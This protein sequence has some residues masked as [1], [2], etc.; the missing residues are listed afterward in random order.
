M[1]PGGSKIKGHRFERKIAH[2][3]SEWWGHPGSFVRTP[4]SGAYA[5]YTGEDLKERLRGDLITPRE[6][7]FF[8]ECKC[9][10]KFEFHHLLENFDSSIFKRWFDALVKKSGKFYP[11]LIFSRNRWDVFM[12]MR[13]DHY[14]SLKLNIPVRMILKVGN[15]SYVFFLMKTFLA[16]VS[17]LRFRVQNKVGEV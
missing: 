10:E 8:I 16:C 3:L 5:Q 9:V 15:E 12:C 13:E 11:L 2:M 14:L 4:G 6:F 7:P 1:K 17:P